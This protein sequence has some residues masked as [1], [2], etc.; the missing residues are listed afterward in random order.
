MKKFVIENTLYLHESVKEN[1]LTSY[2]D[3]N[4]INSSN[5]NN[6]N[7]K[8]TCIDKNI[9][10]LDRLERGLILPLNIQKFAQRKEL[11]N[12]RDT[13]ISKLN[14]TQYEDILNTIGIDILRINLS[15]LN[16]FCDDYKLILE[17]YQDKLDMSDKRKE[18]LVSGLDKRITKLSEFMNSI[19]K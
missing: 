17:K 18:K 1:R 9:K 3:V 12:K 14:L 15:N 5:N 2:D 19:N 6:N 8:L 4:L 10:R 7:Y 16:E 13:V 11:L